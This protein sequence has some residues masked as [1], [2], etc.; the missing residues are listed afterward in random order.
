MSDRPRPR[1]DAHGNARAPVNDCPK[2]GQKTAFEAPRFHKFRK[3]DYWDIPDPHLE[4][5]CIR[6]HYEAESTTLDVEASDE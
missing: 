5:R 6:C 1:I 4:W 2:C 3:M